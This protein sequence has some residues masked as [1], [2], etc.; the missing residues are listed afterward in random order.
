[1]LEPLAAGSQGFATGM[2]CGIAMSL[3]GACH[4]FSLQSK[5]KLPSH[6]CVQLAFVEIPRVV[7]LQIP[8]DGIH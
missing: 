1:M 2:R 7:I 8:T 5:K 6:H 3:H 4:V